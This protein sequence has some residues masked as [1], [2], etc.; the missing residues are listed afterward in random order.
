MTRAT[1][2]TCWDGRNPGV[3]VSGARSRDLAP[4][5]FVRGAAPPAPPSK[6]VG[7]PP[8]LG[9]GREPSRPPSLRSGRVRGGSPPGRDGVPPPAS[10]GPPPCGRRLI[11]CGGCRG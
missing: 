6:L 3:V 4:H 7:A 10:L 11:L 5:L 8:L 9:G 2:I 1:A